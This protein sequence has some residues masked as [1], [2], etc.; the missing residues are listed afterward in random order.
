MFIPDVISGIGLPLLK[1]RKVT[2]INW[3]VL[4]KNAPYLAGLVDGEGSFIIH[5]NKSKKI[6]FTPLIRIGM[7][8]K[9]T[10]KFVADIFGVDVQEQEM[11]PP[12]KKMFY[13]QVGT[14]K[15]ILQIIDALREWSKT[16]LAQMNLLFEFI[17]LKEYALKAKI[18]LEHRATYMKL[19]D[20]YIDLRKLNERGTPPDY[21]LM[22]SFLKKRVEER[23]SKA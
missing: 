13:A 15:E 1:S 12:R 7:T 17:L 11:E 19:V 23:F 2:D 4:K 5:I 18:D 21:K 8:D 20:K 10:I 22:R 3:A 9:N 14:T 6:R 16:K